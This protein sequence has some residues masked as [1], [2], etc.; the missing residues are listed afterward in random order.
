MLQLVVIGQLTSWLKLHHCSWQSRVEKMATTA[1]WWRIA[2]VGHESHWLPIGVDAHQLGSAG[3]VAKAAARELGLGEVAQRRLE[4]TLV[5]SGK[6]EPSA[7]ECVA[8]TARGAIKLTADLSDP[9][10]RE[11]VMPNKAWLLLKVNALPTTGESHVDA[12]ALQAAPLL[13]LRLSSRHR[14]IAFQVPRSSPY[15]LLPLLPVH[16]SR[17]WRRCRASR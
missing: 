4:L 11:R 7:A 15:L 2:Q 8:A 16:C 10:E 17:R 12:R 3:A 9:E 14:A 1:F 5:S 6:D 13:T